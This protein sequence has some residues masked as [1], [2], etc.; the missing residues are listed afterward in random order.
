MPLVGWIIA[1]IGFIGI[2]L[3]IAPVVNLPEQLQFSFAVWSC[4]IAVGLAIAMFTRR[5]KN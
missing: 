3:T 1:L 5:G 2:V 4:V